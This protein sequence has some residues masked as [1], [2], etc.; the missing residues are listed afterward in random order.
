MCDVGRI[1]AIGIAM[2]GFC[3]IFEVHTAG[4][5]VRW[6]KK[7]NIYIRVWHIIETRRTWQM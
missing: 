4:D 7:G 6:T 1:K 5:G 2:L 3:L